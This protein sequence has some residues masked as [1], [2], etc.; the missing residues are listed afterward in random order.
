MGATA[1]AIIGGVAALGGTAASV[2]GA[3]QSGPQ[4]LTP[5]RAL[6]SERQG[7]QQHGPALLA[8][9]WRDALWNAA[10][11]SQAQEAGL[12]GTRGGPR[13]VDYLTNT[14][15]R[16]T[17]NFYQ[18]ESEG[19]L[20][21][22]ARAQ[23]HVFAM[24][25]AR[26]EFEADTMTDILSEFSPDIYEAY[27]AYDPDRTALMDSLTRSAQS[28]LDAGSTNAYED[29]ETQQ[30]IRAG[31]A[32]RG[33]GFGNADLVEEAIGLDR[34]REARRLG[35]GEYAARILGLRTSVMPD[36]ASILLGRS[37]AGGGASI[38]GQAAFGNIAQGPGRSPL[39]D[40]ALAG[41]GQSSALA[42][43]SMRNQSYNNI[44]S[45]LGGLGNLAL[46]Y[47]LSQQQRTNTG[48]NSGQLGAGRG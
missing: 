18:P 16:R 11:A 45:S 27:R 46:Q 40:P 7:R 33:M 17:A 28:E 26:S 42:N 5:R 21:L 48:T 34:G 8:F 12:F 15:R 25:R 14:G 22:M 30:S 13:S 6:L 32:A 10:L 9:D 35:R 3:S 43:I 1:A 24:E 4:P 19:V 47:A 31:Q 39:L 37:G 41:I 29:R 23:P 44:A 20:A 38:L 36:P 2:Y